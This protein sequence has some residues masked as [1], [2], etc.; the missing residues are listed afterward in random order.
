MM[1][2]ENPVPVPL[3][4]PHI[5]NAMVRDEP[6]PTFFDGEHPRSGP[7]RYG[8]EFFL[9]SGQILYDLQ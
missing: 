4:P 5:T 7:K 2:E 8:T 3:Y 9:N 1:T 6:R